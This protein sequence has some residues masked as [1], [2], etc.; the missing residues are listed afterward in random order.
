[1]EIRLNVMILKHGIILNDIDITL[2][3][4]EWVCINS[5]MQLKKDNK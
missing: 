5:Y 2:H 4:I 1:M 3:C